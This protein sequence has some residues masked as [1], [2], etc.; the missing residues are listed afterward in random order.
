VYSLAAAGSDNVRTASQLGF[1]YTAD[2][3]KA[4]AA[5]FASAFLTFNNTNVFGQQ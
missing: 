5:D 3:S 4:L 1:W 2:Y